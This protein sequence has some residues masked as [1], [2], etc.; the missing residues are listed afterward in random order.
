[1]IGNDIPPLQCAGQL[2]EN[3]L[4]ALQHE[5]RWL[6]GCRRVWV[7]NNVVNETAERRVVRALK[8][9]GYG[10]EHRPA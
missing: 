5:P 2:Y 4:Y 8:A 7:V 6:A 9:H 1:M 3:T 10:D